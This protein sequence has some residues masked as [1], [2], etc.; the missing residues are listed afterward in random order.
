MDYRAMDRPK[1]GWKKELNKETKS[2]KVIAALLSSVI[3][4]TIYLPFCIC[5]CYRRFYID[6]RSQEKVKGASKV[7]VR[8]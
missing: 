8:S 1:D 7:K 3:M 6:S 5:S 2:D 4:G